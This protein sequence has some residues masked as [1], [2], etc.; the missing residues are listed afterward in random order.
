MNSKKEISSLTI[1]IICSDERGDSLVNL[2]KRK[3]S[4]LYFLKAGKCRQY[5]P[6][7]L[8]GLSIPR[9]QL[10]IT[11]DAILFHYTDL[12]LWKHIQI[13]ADY[14]FEFNTPGTPQ[15]RPNVIPIYR[16]TF[17]YFAIHPDDINELLEFV[18]HKKQTKPRMCQ[19]SPFL[20]LL[21]ALDVLCKYYLEFNSKQAK[22]TD[23][24]PQWW[25]ESL[26]LISQGSLNQIQCHIVHEK[27]KIE[28]KSSEQTSGIY[29]L[30]EHLLEPQAEGYSTGKN[31][32][33]AS[34]VNTLFQDLRL[35][36][37]ESKSTE[38]DESEWEEHVP[39]ALLYVEGSY[40]ASSTASI[41]ANH[42]CIPLRRLDTDAL[43]T[44]FPNNFEKSTLILTEEQIANL[45]ALRYRWSFTG[46]V[47]V[48]SYETFATLK[49]KHRVLRF[50]QGSHNAITIPFT[51]TTLISKVK[52]LLPMEKENL[53]FLQNELRAIDTLYDKEI[54]PSLEKLEQPNNNVA[55]DELTDLIDKLR[56]QTPVACHTVVTI[57]DKTQQIQQ[58]LRY[59]LGQLRQQ[60]N[61]DN[62]L[63]YLKD[64]F[65]QW[66]DL[67]Q[68]AA[69]ESLRPVP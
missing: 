22:E 62:L 13:E 27:L 16:Q 23:L 51:L 41:I 37:G 55:L 12:R 66:R 17:P 33:S 57:H 47:L 56:S 65:A 44:N 31:Q 39:N 52:A 32:I 29:R 24:K 69:G 4:K 19:P 20:D 46:A 54:K 14:T 10:P 53:R 35:I 67:V 6:D 59:A 28:A 30:F 2:L 18:S 3:V 21:P 36:F 58:H 5:T 8:T 60:N 64:I 42:L 48:L 45:P 1:I 38:A 15:A 40:L 25:L 61:R 63:I 49:Q 11:A 34:V 43:D 50:G 26:G 7:D 9:S 68:S